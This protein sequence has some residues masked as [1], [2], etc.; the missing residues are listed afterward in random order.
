M[1]HLKKKVEFVHLGG[2]IGNESKKTNQILRLNQEFVH[3][4]A[5]LAVI[6]R[7]DK[8]INYFG[9]SNNQNTK[10]QYAFD[11]QETEGKEL[12]FKTF[13]HINN[14]IQY[15]FF[16]RESKVMELD[17][18][19]K[20]MNLADLNT[21]G[22]DENTRG[23]NQACHSLKNVSSAML[24]AEQPDEDDTQEDQEEEEGEELNPLYVF[25]DIQEKT[26]AL[27][28]LL[29]EVPCAQLSKFLEMR[30]P[31][32]TQIYK[33]IQGFRYIFKY[34]LKLPEEEIK[35]KNS[36]LIKL[37]LGM[38]LNGIKNSDR[39]DFIAWVREQEFE[40]TELDANDESIPE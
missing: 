3:L 37:Y 34:A 39:V 18:I 13:L 31:D 26:K 7:N 10:I 14:F 4:E 8:I 33:I 36:N 2:I 32:G 35:F 12:R 17:H 5:T 20:M 29:R 11:N 16:D 27:R 40:D 6:L 28:E 19:R 25:L 30:V 24:L 23:F 1:E 21:E 15:S 38:P 9:D 22:Q